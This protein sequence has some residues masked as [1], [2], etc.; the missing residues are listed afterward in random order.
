MARSGG[1]GAGELRVLTP[2]SASTASGASPGAAS[3]AG[4]SPTLTR[5]SVS[6]GVGDGTDALSHR[7]PARH[8]PDLGAVLGRRRLRSGPPTPPGAAP[9][10]RQPPSWALTAAAMRAPSAW[11]PTRL[12]TAPMTFPLALGSSAPPAAAISSATTAARASSSSWAGSR[13][14]GARPPAVRWRPA[15]CGRPGC[16]SR[17]PR[18]ASSL[19]YGSRPAPPRR[20]ARPVT[21]RRSR[22]RWTAVITSRRV[23]VRTWFTRLHGG[24]EIGTQV[25]DDGHAHPR[26]SGTTRAAALPGLDRDGHRRARVRA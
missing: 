10:D 3:L 1:V 4:T 5:P 12:R 26:P 23:E 19:R 21:C 24:G 25:V 20:R 18:C 16:R 17:P 11:S 15:R 9:S 13:R 14:P 7:G 22:P 8:V 6:A 2:T